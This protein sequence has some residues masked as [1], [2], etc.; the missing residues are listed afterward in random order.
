MHMNLFKDSISP[1]FS[2]ILPLVPLPSPLARN[3]VRWCFCM[4]TNCLQ[5]NEKFR[6][7]MHK[8]I[9]GMKKKY[10]LC[11]P[12]EFIFNLNGNINMQK[13]KNKRPQQ[14]QK[15]EQQLQC[16]VNDRKHSG[17]MNNMRACIKLNLSN[18]YCICK[19]GKR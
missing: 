19:M 15:I 14:Q 3:Y 7:K 16:I 13:S 18:S 6:K 10:W 4:H 17:K 11:S 2:L 1:I 5:V 8:R 9:D 12:V